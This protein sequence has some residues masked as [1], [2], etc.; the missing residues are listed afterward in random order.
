VGERELAMYSSSS[1]LDGGLGGGKRWLGLP[2]PTTAA[3]A[4]GD[5]VHQAGGRGLISEREVS[6]S[7]PGNAGSIG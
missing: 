6:C 1:S 7:W 4:D 5:R 2:T 3:D